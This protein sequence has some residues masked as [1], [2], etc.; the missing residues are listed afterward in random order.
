[1]SYSINV[2]PIELRQKTEN[3][4]LSLDDVF[5]FIE[6]E[7]NLEKFTDSQLE[8]IEKHLTRRDYKFEK[9]Y[10]NRTDYK[11]TKYSSISVMLTPIGLFFNARGEDGIMEISMTAGEFGYYLSLKGNFA[12][13]DSQ[14]G[15]WQK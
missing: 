14:N 6:K 12:V 11:H 2:Y 13:F 4:G 5:N 7:S 10:Q 15:G 1:M 8:L 9:Q 3:L